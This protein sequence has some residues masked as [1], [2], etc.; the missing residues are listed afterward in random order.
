M[1]KPIKRGWARWR[2]GCSVAAFAAVCLLAWPQ[3]AVA[4]RVT[5]QD[6]KAAF[7]FNFA[8][9]T[10]WPSDTLAAGRPLTLCVMGDVS[11]VDALERAISGRHVEGHELAVQIVTLDDPIRS[12]Q[13]LYAGGLDAEHS[14]ELLQ[15]LRG[16]AVFTV[17]DSD[18]FAESG[19][20]AQLIFEG[21]RMRFAI[22]VASARRA[23]LTLSSKLLGLAKLVKD[24]PNVPR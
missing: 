16:A 11:V 19:G 5:M 13:L 18:R 4:Q 6:V 9:F 22:N 24:G 2:S 7:L 1:D 10:E 8:A 14:V 23:R 21:D 3:R 12:C 20:V 17:G 15:A